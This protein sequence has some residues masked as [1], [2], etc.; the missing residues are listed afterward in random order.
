MRRAEARYFV[1]NLESM[2]KIIKIT[3][4]AIIIIIIVALGSAPRKAYAEAM[5]LELRDAID[6]ALQKNESYRI[7][8]K[9]MEKA[10][11]R[12]SEAVAGALPQVTGGL[13]YLKNWR[14]PTGVFQMDGETIA[15]KFGTE[16]RYI[17]DLTVT[18]PIYVGGR[19]FTALKIARTY[20]KMTRELTKSARQELK[21]AVFNSFFG[22]I[23]ADE[24]HRVNRESYE[25][26]RQNL[27]VVE[28]MFNQGMAAE[29]DYL[30]A[31][32]TVA[33]LEPDVIKS[34]NDRDLA[35][36]ALKN[37]LGVDL[38]TDID[39]EVD[40]DS[41]QF[42]IPPLQS[43]EAVAELKGNRPEIIVSGYET[44]MR[45][46][47]VSLAKADYKPS[48]IFSSSLQYQSQF[49]EG[50]VFD[51]K[52]DRSLSSALILSVP[53]FDSWKTPGKVKQANV[54]MVQ[55]RL[56]EE[57]VVKYM[58]LDYEQSLGKYGEARKRLSVQ[59]GAVEL[60]R[61]GL[62]IANVR[63]ENGV[64]TQIE[65]SDA[66]LSLARAEINRA[67]A[68]HDL[69]TGYASLLRALGREVE[70]AKQ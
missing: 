67:V 50:N 62:E 1:G 70:P 13:T 33:N 15:F 66:R 6:V 17:A 42:V 65:V 9:E 52:W 45:R 36:K 28:K 48:L 40:F 55:S 44:G 12:I 60:A 59:G 10:D 69:A 23:L 8:N 58:I 5:K 51:K 41:T 29:F 68:F 37:V 61:R 24:I 53:I 32:V 31:R 14:I 57:S 16:D 34:G 2:T 22:A 3:S 54:E 27:D 56:K 21:V 39:L 20:K 43:D 63:Y 19:T 46:Q 47:L 25:L 11:G 35:M 26:A 7:A 64:G 4:A 38:D 49:N 30:R 18:Q